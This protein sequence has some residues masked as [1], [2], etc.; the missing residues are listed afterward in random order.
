MDLDA[1][2]INPAGLQRRQQVLHRPH[3]L[4]LTRQRRAERR[5]D[6]V[7]DRRRDPQ[8]S[9][10]S[11]HKKIP[12]LAGHR[13]EQPGGDRNPRVET[14]PRSHYFRRQRLL[15]LP[16][17]IKSTNKAKIQCGIAKYTSKIGESKFLK[18]KYSHR[19]P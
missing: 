6:G 18:K 10:S 19:P 3:L 11:P 7:I 17:L 1:A 8:P 12:P 14:D 16:Q 13:R 5:F 2:V 9:I 15:R 4:S